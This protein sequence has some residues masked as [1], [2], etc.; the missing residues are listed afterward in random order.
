MSRRFFLRAAGAT[1]ALPTLPSLF[2]SALAVR[3]LAAE[4]KPDP[5]PGAAAGARRFC[6]I[7]F[8]NGVSLPPEN[9]PLHREW[10]WFPH[11][12]GADYR[13]MKPLEPLEPLRREF[14]I[15]SGLSHPALRKMVG[16]A[17][18]DSF[19]TAADQ[20]HGYANSIS[21]DQLYAEAVGDQTRFPS[22]TLSSDGG[23]GTPGRAK[24]L[25][26]T[27][28]GKPIPALSEPRVIF[29]R[30]FGVEERSVAEQRRAIGQQRS[31]LD[32]IA[33]ETRAMERRLDAADRSRLQ[34]YL[35]S[36]REI[37]QRLERSD[38]WLDV[39]KPAVKPD[40]FRL[41]ATPGGDAQDYL[42]GILDLMHA[43]LLTDSTRSLTYQ[44]T[45]EDAKG[46]GDRFPSALGLKGHHNL[47]HA[48]GT[49]NGYL[50]WARYDRFLTEQFAYFLERMRA[51]KDPE[52]DGSLLD[53]TV[54]L[55]G[56]STSRTHKASNYPLILAGAQRLGLRHGRHLQF[57]ESR[58]HLSNLYVTLLR[59]LGMPVEQFGDSNGRADEV[60]G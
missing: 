8:P 34:E 5:A 55:Y 7:F 52:N 15:L 31:I 17:T 35:T 54:V 22:L 21:L 33:G 38:R 3:G 50:E 45:A 49:E 2:G 44:V 9:H 56:C 25:S 51:T 39:Q 37:E 10:H 18:A 60:L 19:L 48:T 12:T 4:A 40:A 41:D 47:S 43:A 14:T 11:E 46:I 36:V 29:N 27:R 42:R 13:L 32:S 58:V 28:S 24:T 26:F 16:H 57:D 23:T 59:Q 1:L 30:L 6:C 53:N 20:T